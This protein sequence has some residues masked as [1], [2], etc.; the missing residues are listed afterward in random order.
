MRFNAKKA[1]M[2][3]C[4]LYIALPVII[5]FL[6]W[7][8]L[9]IAIPAAVIF[10][11]CVYRMSV[12]EHDLWLPD[13]DRRMILV[14]VAAFVLIAVWVLISGIG[15]YYFQDTDHFD[16]NEIFSLLVEKRWPVVDTY[17]F[18]GTETTRMMVYYLG[19]WLPSAVIGK[20]FG[21]EA[22]WGFQYFW[23]FMGIVLIFILLSSL[24]K[25]YNFFTILGFM[26][27]SGMDILGAI[28]CYG[29][30]EP[31]E[32]IEWWSGFQY[33]SN[34]T[35]LFWVFNQAI[36]G[37]LLILLILVQKNNR[38]IGFIL[39]CSLLS[40][41]FPFVG[42]IPFSVAKIINN[43]DKDNN[44]HINWTSSL[45]E[46]FSPENIL[47]GGF[48]GIISFIFLKTNASASNTDLAYFSD[49]TFWG[50]YVFFC[51]LEFGILLL[52]VFKD[53]RKNPLYIIT[54]VSLLICPFVRIGDSQDFCMRA[55]IPALTV[56]YI[57][58]CINVKENFHNRSYLRLALLLLIFG[59][60]IMT[61]FQE[62]SRH[63]INMGV[64][65]E[66][67]L[68]VKVYVPEEYVM[69]APNFSCDVNDSFFY[70]YLSR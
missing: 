42:L 10:A 59:I 15:G 28:I 55:S 7:V 19:F 64:I 32:H 45:K 2:T 38:H 3:S 70:M 52:I 66:N 60:G 63:V 53:E 30:V 65:R 54:A 1:I 33:S 50:R 29:I 14:T 39:G 34:T 57:I 16:R 4:Y 24:I 48:S 25:S 21:I 56:L 51:L 23:A 49:P 62:I 41:T 67:D 69:G 68:D 11:F 61:P 36:Y 22:G 43:L 58:F 35:L 18:N 40:S 8:K 17:I 6:G 27:F 37:W 47:G 20:I 12:K 46:L 44:K 26:L 5:F 9:Y 31:G 13:V